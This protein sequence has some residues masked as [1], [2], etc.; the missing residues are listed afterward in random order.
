MTAS[1]T[2]FFPQEAV[3]LRFFGAYC[4]KIIFPETMMRK[5]ILMI[6][7]F[8]L[9]ALPV[10]A[11]ADIVPTPADR[12]YLISAVAAAYPDTGFAGRVG[13]CAVILN[14]MADAGFP[15]TAASVI[16]SFGEEY[17]SVTSAPD[18]KSLRL[19]HDALLAAESGN[20]PTNSALYFT[21]LAENK[22][23]YDFRFDN[24][25]EKQRRRKMEEATRFCTTVVDGIGFYR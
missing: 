24:F 3:F 4:E 18:E 8:I 7:V 20:D 9:L 6:S 21:V 1:V 25:G 10:S 15:D 14:R 23:V 19:T 2:D 12:Q 13:I 17:F 16:A 5:F 22:P 11:A